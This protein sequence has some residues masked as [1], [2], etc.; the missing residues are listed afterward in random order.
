MKLI[1]TDKFS[2]SLR[3]K[4][5][6]LN[7]KK[8]LVTRFSGSKQ[9][10]DFT[11]PA[12]CN[13]LGRIRHFRRHA[14]SI[15]VNPLPMDPAQKSLGLMSSGDIRAQ[16]FQNAVC[17]WRCWYCYVDFDLLSGNQNHSEWVSADDLIDLYLENVDRP[18]MI[19]LSGGQPDLVPEWTAWMIDALSRRGLA[20]SVYLWSDDNLS[21]DYF[22]RFLT[23]NQIDK[24][25]SYPNYGRVGCF[26]GIDGESFE[27]NT[28]AE[29]SIFERQFDIFRRLLD[30]GIDLYGYVTLTVPNGKNLKGKIDAFL[31]RLQSVHENLPLRTVPL[32]IGI[33]TPVKERP[34]V[35]QAESLLN[36][37]DE[38]IQ[39]WREAIDQRFSS[40]LIHTKISDISLKK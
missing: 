38:A 11:V 31:D 17:N 21:N 1:Q 13:G 39:F 29:S 19:D 40:E 2:D 15:W 16:V 32:K 3:R 36:Y 7:N 24:I 10:K 5:I 35:G 28:Q 14:E 9:E 20:D 30:V 8:I 33:F 23:P 18:D 26:K 4:G 37:Q 6:D 25:A 12:N 34:Q 27:F 22:F